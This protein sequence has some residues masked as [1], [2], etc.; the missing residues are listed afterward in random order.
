MTDPVTLWG[1][2]DVDRSGKVRWLAAELGVPVVER[3]VAPGDH[4]RKPYIDMNPLAQIPTAEYR[5]ETFI[6][7]TAICHVLAESVREPKLWVG[8]GEPNR[9]K[10]LFWLAAFGETLEGRLVEC[11]VS[12]AGLLGPEH[13]T[14][15]EKRLRPKLTA[16]T[17]MLPR[18]GYLCGERFTVAD[19]LAGYSL[20]LAVNVALVDRSAVEPYLG[21]LVAR[22]AARESRIFASLS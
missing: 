19:V 3:R 8:P 10:Y 13:F 20:R 4:T 16:V 1:F 11:A 14:L 2:G 7:S 9:S 12:R 21:R 5:G 15:H 22:A 18:D 6:E 17:G